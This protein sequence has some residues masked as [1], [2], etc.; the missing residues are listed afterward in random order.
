MLH[1]PEEMAAMRGKQVE[2][3]LP[4]WERAARHQAVEVV[5]PV[6]EEGAGDD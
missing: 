3:V 2:D 5:T 1:S 6:A 4:F